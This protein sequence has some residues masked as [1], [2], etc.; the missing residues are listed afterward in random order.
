MFWKRRL[1]CL[2]RQGNCEFKSG[3]LQKADQLP[4][5]GYRKGWHWVFPAVFSLPFLPLPPL[6]SEVEKMI[7]KFG[8]W[9]RCLPADRGQG[10]S[11]P[12]RLIFLI[13]GVNGIKGP[14]HVS[15]VRIL[16]TGD[17][18]KNHNPPCRTTSQEMLA[19]LFNLYPNFKNGFY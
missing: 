19:F 6:R 11:H 5:N 7:L 3:T 1:L 9:L 16:P 8:C 4:E 17:V 13:C 12:R 10:I 15:V 18:R 2:R 14:L